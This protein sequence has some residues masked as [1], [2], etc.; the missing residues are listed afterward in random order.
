[1]FALFIICGFGVTTGLITMAFINS[2]LPIDHIPVFAFQLVAMTSAFWIL[3]IL[4][5]FA[6]K[7]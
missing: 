7:K 3:G 2:S 6:F 5:L 1:L 4:S